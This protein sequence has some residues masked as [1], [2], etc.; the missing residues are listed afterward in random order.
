MMVSIN[1][2]SNSEENMRHA[3]NECRFTMWYSLLGT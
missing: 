2:I 1:T 3:T